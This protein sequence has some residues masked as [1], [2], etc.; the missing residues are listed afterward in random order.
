M[1]YAIQ[2]GDSGPIKIGFTRGSAK[3]R[4]RDLQTGCPHPLRLLGSC[5]GK[6]Y[7][8]RWLHRVAG[9]A[10]LSGE[11]FSPTDLVMDV[12]ATIVSGEG[13]D[14]YHWF[15]PVEKKPKPKPEGSSNPESFRVQVWREANRA[16]YNSRQREL[17]RKRRAH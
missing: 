1:I 10:R 2:V 7:D 8:E 16:R 9:S 12:V 6:S 3:S 4:M 11:W 15:D 13:F 17:M 14:F 5:P